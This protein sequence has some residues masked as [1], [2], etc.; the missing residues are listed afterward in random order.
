MFLY[1]SHRNTIR[2]GKLR[3]SGSSPLLVDQGHTL[4]TSIQFEKV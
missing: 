1:D 3:S 2:S 4:A